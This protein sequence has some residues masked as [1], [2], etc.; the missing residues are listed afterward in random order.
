MNDDVASAL[1]GNSIVGE[2]DEQA[3]TNNVDQPSTFDQ[4]ESERMESK[5]L[6]F[7]GLFFRGHWANPFQHQAEVCRKYHKPYLLILYIFL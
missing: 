7:N 6:L 1:S 5:M 3:K 4:T 2:K